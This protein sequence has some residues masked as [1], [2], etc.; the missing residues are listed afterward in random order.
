[1]DHLFSLFLYTKLPYFGCLNLYISHYQV[2]YGHD[3]FLQE[4]GSKGQFGAVASILT[5]LPDS[6]VTYSDKTVH[7]VW[8]GVVGTDQRAANSFSSLVKS[9]DQHRAAN[10]ETVLA[11]PRKPGCSLFPSDRWLVTQVGIAL[12]KRCDHEHDWQSGFLLLHNLH[13]Y[14]IH[15]VKLS[16]P[17]S[18]LPPFIPHAPS[19]CEVALLAVKICLEAENISAALEVMRGCEWIRTSVGEELGKRT[20]VLCDLAKKCLEGKMLQEAWKCLENVHSGGKVVAGF[21]N[22]ITNLH[23]R[24]LQDVLMLRDT[25]FA[26][27]VHRKM[28]QCQLQ[29]LPT[30]FSALLQHLCDKKQVCVI[31]CV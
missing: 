18:T 4:N 10:S 12:L 11:E 22:V 14:G 8:K 27:I 31:Q 5:N 24:L 19:P 2:A 29:C 30:V 16:Q 3:F 13:L 25:N 6:S 17:S 26:L 9:L 20:E 15:Y 28:R 7:S 1:M 21:V 23:N